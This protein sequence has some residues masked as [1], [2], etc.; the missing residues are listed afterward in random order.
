MT[1]NMPE[2]DGIDF[3]S[4]VHTLVKRR[5][6][7]ATI[8]GGAA[9]LAIVAALMLPEK[10]TATSRVALP[11]NPEGQSPLGALS[12]LTAVAGLGGGLQ[13]PGDY[14]VGVLQSQRVADSII[15]KFDL[16]RVYGVSSLTDARKKLQDGS[17][18]GMGKGD[19]IQIDVTTTD[20]ELSAAMAT[21]YAAELTATVRDLRDRGA[22][23]RSEFFGGKLAD[24]KVKLGLAHEK[25]KTVREQTG[26][27][28]L[29]GE[30]ES[31]LVAMAS[32]QAQI[33][34]KAALLQSMR[35][36]F[37]DEN[38]R[39]QAAQAELGSLRAELA[40][41]AQSTKGTE[42]LAAKSVEF[43]NGAREARFAEIVYAMMLKQY[44][45][46]QATNIKTAEIVQV[47][48]EATVP[49][50]RSSP[51]RG[52]IVALSTLAAGLLSVFLALALEAF[53]QARRQ[54]PELVEAIRA[55]WAA[56]K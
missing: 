54:R 17:D 34:A 41:R 1:T 8:T 39:V 23:V 22:K 43:L 5:K 12:E 11:E 42:G 24:A 21:A 40:R 52:L 27:L 47:L 29:E 18:I 31:V 32:L 16:K 15:Q 26:I 30:T 20:A 7:I 14:F 9:V 50:K 44:E 6:L 49:D 48:D 38:S 45:A 10:F 13:N 2:A 28:E 46:A 3:M 37:T 56:A 35:V 55:E 36:N 19:I 33:A 4:T 53:E 51:R 25:L